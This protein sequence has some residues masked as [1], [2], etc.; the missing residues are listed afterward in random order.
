V[1]GLTNSTNFPTTGD[2]LQPTSTGGNAFVTKLNATGSGLIYST[3]LGAAGGGEGNG[4]A[5]DE[6]GDIYVTG[7]AN[8]GFPLVHSIPNQ[9]SSSDQQAFV[10]KINPA[11]AGAA[12][13]LYSTLLSG[14]YPTGGNAIAVDKSGDA[15]VTGYTYA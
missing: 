6:G 3:Y 12:A 8:E 7:V 4:I 13:L 5:L 1:T 2:V 10:A 11:Q 15:Y 9:E 14:A